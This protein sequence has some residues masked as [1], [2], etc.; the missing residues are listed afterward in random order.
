MEI[1]IDVQADK[2]ELLTELL[3]HLP[4][5]EIKSSTTLKNQVLQDLQEAVDQVNAHKR[6]SI[7]LRQARG[8]INAL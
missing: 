2:A 8:L 1:V 7:Q 6:G 5:V 4:F 3:N